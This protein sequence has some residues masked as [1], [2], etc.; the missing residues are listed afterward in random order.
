[1][2]HRAHFLDPLT[3]SLSALLWGRHGVFP[4]GFWPILGRWSIRI[5]W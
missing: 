5:G 1:V 4:C 2:A 3:N